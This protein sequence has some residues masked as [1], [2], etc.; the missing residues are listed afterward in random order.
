MTVWEKLWILFSAYFTC[1]FAML[2][3]CRSTFKG[4]FALGTI[5]FIISSVYVATFLLPPCWRVISPYLSTLERWFIG[6]N[7][8]PISFR[9]PWSGWSMYC[10]R[11]ISHKGPQRLPCRYPESLREESHTVSS[12]IKDKRVICGFSYR[13][14]KTWL[15]AS[16]SWVYSVRWSQGIRPRMSWWKRPGGAF[17][18]L[19]GRHQSVPDTAGPK[20]VKAW[21]Q[22][23]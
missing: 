7:F 10:W 2:W 9:V 3:M 20:Y 8:L 5:K 1:S 12:P 11:G 19:C 6:S 16:W 23:L 15:S 4:M 17:I 21:T 13:N 18:H 14:I 22:W